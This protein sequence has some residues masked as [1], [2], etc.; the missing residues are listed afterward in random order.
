MPTDE[1]PKQTDVSEAVEDG[2]SNPVIQPIQ[3]IAEA[4]A[5]DDLTSA[6]LTDYF[7]TGP[8][9][10]PLPEDPKNYLAQPGVSM[11]VFEQYL[12]S[13][14]IVAPTSS[15]PTG[16]QNNIYFLL[17]DEFMHILRY[18]QDL[19]RGKGAPT[20]IQHMMHLIRQSVKQHDLTHASYERALRHHKA[21]SD[22]AKAEIKRIEEEFKGECSPCH[23]QAAFARGAQQVSSPR[24]GKV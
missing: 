20:K 21:H 7:E 17:R 13:L 15:S 3:P 19:L 8:H 14:G 6:R 12:R 23:W 10:G 4:P 1:P 2:T 5:K 18:F 22:D 9:Y 24:T 16:P 11:R